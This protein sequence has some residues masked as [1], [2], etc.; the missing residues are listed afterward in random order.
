MGFQFALSVYTAN[1][2]H[3]G[4]NFLPIKV[5]QKTKN[6]T[7]EKFIKILFRIFYYN[8]CIRN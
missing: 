5:H 1:A 7:N 3:N 6:Q 8:R 2:I 4:K